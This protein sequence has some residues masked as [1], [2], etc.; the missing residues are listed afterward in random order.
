MGLQGVSRW[1]TAYPREDLLARR[2]W[3]QLTLIGALAMPSILQNSFLEYLS[4]LTPVLG[5]RYY[6]PYCTDVNKDG[7]SLSNPSPAYMA[8]EGDRIQT[9]QSAVGALVPNALSTS[10]QSRGWQAFPGMTQIVTV[11]RLSRP[12]SFCHNLHTLPQSTESDS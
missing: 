10:N 6:Y 1:V 12:Y 4:I 5:C 3:S 9:Q 8:S 11:F 2:G 7:E